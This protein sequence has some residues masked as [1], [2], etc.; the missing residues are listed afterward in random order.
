MGTHKRLTE[1]CN[2]TRNV[3]V[4]QSCERA[5]ERWNLGSQGG[6]EFYEDF[7]TRG[8]KRKRCL[9]CI[10]EMKDAIQ[11]KIKDYR[12]QYKLKQFS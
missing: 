11:F 6:V 7:P 4:C 3:K 8:I 2:P 10:K 12:S 9:Y 1:E 5:W